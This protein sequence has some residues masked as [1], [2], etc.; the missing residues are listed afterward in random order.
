MKISIT[1]C[2]PCNYLPQATSLAAKISKEF[3]IEPELI[4]GTNGVLMLSL[5]TSSFFPNTKLAAS[6]MKRKFSVIYGSSKLIIASMTENRHTDK[7]GVD[8]EK[9]NMVTVVG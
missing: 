3:G 5:T 4:K 8:R 9:I 7:G 6:L 2:V 1:Y